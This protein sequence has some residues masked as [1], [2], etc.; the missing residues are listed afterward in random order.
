MWTHS[1]PDGFRGGIKFYPN[2]Q[3]GNILTFMTINPEETENVDTKLSDAIIA[4]QENQDNVS[5]EV[6]HSNARSYASI[7]TPVSG[8]DST[9]LVK[10]VVIFN[11]PNISAHTGNIFNGSNFT[12]NKGQ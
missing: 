10:T 11:N 1:F 12:I 8:S 7:D 2:G 3:A 4:I 6:G 9:I 5:I